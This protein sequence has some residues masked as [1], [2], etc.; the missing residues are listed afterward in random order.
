MINY[1]IKF[2]DLSLSTVRLFAYEENTQNKI[3]KYSLIDAK[4]ALLPGNNLYIMLPSGLFGF[5]TTKN[6]TG[7]KDEI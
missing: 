7:L 5:R 3:E 4:E 6:E 2:D 1:F